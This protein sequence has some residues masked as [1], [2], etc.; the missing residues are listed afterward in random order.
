MLTL[1]IIILKVG[2][3]PV[4]AVPDSPTAEELA[5]MAA[6]EL[7]I[8][9]Y[10]EVQ[11]KITTWAP[12]ILGKYED[13]INEDRSAVITSGGTEYLI[14]TLPKSRIVGDVPSYQQAKTFFSDRCGRLAITTDVKGWLDSNG[15]VFPDGGE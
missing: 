3:M 15:Y 11:T 1:I 4:Y 7:R 9:Y 8:E 10:N 13:V 14:A 5:A 12:I 2:L 6:Y